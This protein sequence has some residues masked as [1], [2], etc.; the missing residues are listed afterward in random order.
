VMA[1][2]S[3]IGGGWIAD[4]IGGIKCMLVVCIVT[5]A[6][7]F[8]IVTMPPFYIVVPALIILFLALGAGNGSTFQLVPLRWVGSTAIVMSLVGEV[9]GLGGGLIPNVMGYSRQYLGRYHYGFIVWG[10]LAIGIF[11]MYM[12]VKRRWERTWVGA[13]GKALHREEKSYDTP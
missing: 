6:V 1:S 7:S 13:G 8:F 3:R 9:G 4:R 2:I 10:F 11:V 5:S 12:V